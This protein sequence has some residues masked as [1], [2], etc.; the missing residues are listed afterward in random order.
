MM[1]IEI[2]VDS[3]DSALAAQRGEVT[4]VELCSALREGGLTPSL[5][6]IQSV[7]SALTIQV[8]VMIRPR[9]GDYVYSANEFQV[10]KKNVLNAKVSGSDGVVLGLLT[11]QGE[12][13]IPRTRQLVELARPLEVTFHRA[14]DEARGLETALEAVIECG[15]HRI[16]T[17][18]GASNASSGARTLARLQAQAR[19]RIQ[20]MAGGGIRPNNVTQLLRE[21]GIRAVHS[22]LTNLPDESSD[23]AC[24][25]GW[26][27]VRAVDVAELRLNAEKALA[28]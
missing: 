3:L 2:C 20:I 22:A 7:R 17:S 8:F 15:V 6:M 11:P 5:E 9:G 13:D 10:M 14:F 21:T 16:L 1:Q 24:K 23:L 27:V 25:G 19:G 18:G 12:V 28:F 4:R 26:P